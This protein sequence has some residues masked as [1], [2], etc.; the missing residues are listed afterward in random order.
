MKESAKD[1]DM[2]Y[3]YFFFLSPYRNGKDQQIGGGI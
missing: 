3:T 1:F 2:D